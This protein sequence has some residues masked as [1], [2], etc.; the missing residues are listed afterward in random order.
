MLVNVFFHLRRPFC[1]E[2]TNY[3]LQICGDY[4]VFSPQG[5]GVI[6]FRVSQA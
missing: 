1:G 2:K 3:S 4:F 5:V 6:H